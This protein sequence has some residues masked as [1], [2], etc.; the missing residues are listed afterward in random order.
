MVCPQQFQTFF[1]SKGINE[2]VSN[3]C[4]ERYYNKFVLDEKMSH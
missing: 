2:T 1:S 3:T 4:C